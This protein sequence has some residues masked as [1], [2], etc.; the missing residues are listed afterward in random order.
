MPIFPN[1][2][3]SEFRNCYPNID[4]EIKFQEKKFTEITNH[5]T[6]MKIKLNEIE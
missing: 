4:F 3:E 6:K 1:H 5:P 2:T